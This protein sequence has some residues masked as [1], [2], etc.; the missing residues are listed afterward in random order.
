MSPPTPQKQNQKSP[1]GLAQGHNAGLHHHQEIKVME[2]W[3]SVENTNCSIIATIC[4]LEKKKKGG[5][6][7][8]KEGV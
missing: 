1:E 3:M 5:G 7:A 4:L 6:G 2:F 8:Q